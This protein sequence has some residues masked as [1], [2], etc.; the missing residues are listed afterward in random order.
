MNIRKFLNQSVVYWAPD[1]NDANGNVQYLAPVDMR[2]RIVTATRSKSTPVSDINVPEAT[3]LCVDL[4][5][6]EG[7][8]AMGTVADFN[9]F[10]TMPNQVAD[11]VEINNIMP[12][13]DRKGATLG[14]EITTKSQFSMG[15]PL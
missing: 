10:L 6:A 15:W 14:Y 1:G 4:V 13:V 12:F 2:I 9:G 3:I 8:F 5:Q 11:S 7:R